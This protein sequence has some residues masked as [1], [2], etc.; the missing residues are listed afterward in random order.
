MCPLYIYIYIL[1]LFFLMNL[2]FLF[3][4]DTKYSILI[5][6]IIWF[7]AIISIW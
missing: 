7:E 6:M 4:Y 1:V 3:I 2:F 5:Q